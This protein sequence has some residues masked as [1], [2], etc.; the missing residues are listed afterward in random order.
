MQNSDN[1]TATYATSADA[2]SGVGAYPILA[3]LVDPDGKLTNYST[4]INNGSLT[5]NPA[6]LSVTA[7]NQTK[8][9]GAANPILTGTL[10]GVQNGDN[11]TATYATAADNSSGV[12]TYSILATLV[13]PDGKLANYTTTINNGSLVI[14]PAALIGTADNQT[15]LYGQANPAFTVTY[16]GFVN[17]ENTS[18]I[19]GTLLASTVADTITARLS[20][21]YADVTVSGQSAANYKARHL[22]GRNVECHARAGSRACQ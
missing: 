7:D 1:I 16:S 8:I 18:V 13:D 4:T 5:V 10:T 11:I 19:T 20:R 12:G 22:C 2:S 21:R 3:T 14:N 15:R 6:A 9:Y 17:S